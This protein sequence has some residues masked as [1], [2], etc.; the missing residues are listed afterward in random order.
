MRVSLCLGLCLAMSVAGMAN[1]IDQKQLIN[2]DGGSRSYLTASN[3]AVTVNVSDGASGEAGRF[4]IGTV[5]GELLLY[6]HGTWDPS[7]TYVRMMVDGTAFGPPGSGYFDEYFTLIS[8]P[9]LVGNS[10]ATTYGAGDVHLTQTVTPDFVADQGTIRIEYDVVNTN[11][12]A[13]EVR[14]MLEMD[15]QIDWNDSAPIWTSNGYVAEETCYFGASVPNIWQAF[16]ND[17]AQPPEDLVGCGILDGFGA[18]PPDQFAHG[19]WGDFYSA[20]FDYVCDGETYGDSAVLLWWET[21]VLEPDDSEHYQTFYGTCDVNVVPGDL[22]ITMGGTPGL[23]CVNDQIAPNPFDVNVLVTNTGG[24]DCEN[25]MVDI[26]VDP[27]Y[28]VIGP[29]TVLLGTLAGG[30]APGAA[31]F[32][33]EATGT[34]CDIELGFSVFVTSDNCEPNTARNVMWVPCCDVVDANDNPMAFE[35]KQNYPNPFNP[36]TTISFS[37]SET[38]PVEL[39]VYS[40]DGSRV[41]TIMEGLASNGRH[42][43]NFDASA[44]QSG[45][46]VYTLS[47]SEGSISKKMLFIK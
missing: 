30:G 4:T 9:A 12:A 10:I 11:G 14:I 42:D 38:G 47:T 46:Y 7:T 34:P 35:L 29:S 24:E 19:Q 37:L 36:A 16:E 28:L 23:S 44:L 22:S 6:G 27:G 45:V 17:P 5:A 25:V 43:V 2:E 3:A 26:V 1:K 21:G 31:N 13:H 40:L 15:T 41:A 20:S 33:V 18:T 8:D 39:A 32:L